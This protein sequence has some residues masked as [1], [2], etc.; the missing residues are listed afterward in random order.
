M[1]IYTKYRYV[2][3][4]NSFVTYGCKYI[5]SA[6]ALI[7][8]SAS[9]RVQNNV[10]NPEEIDFQSQPVQCFWQLPFHLRNI[11][12]PNDKL[13]W[14][15][16]FLISESAIRCFN[17][18]SSSSMHYYLLLEFIMWSMSKL[19]SYT[20]VDRALFASI[21]IIM[22]FWLNKYTLE[23]NFRPDWRQTI[24]INTHNQFMP[25]TRSRLILWADA[26]AIACVGDLFSKTF[27]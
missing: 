19:C 21:I 18:L 16:I 14:I 11:I 26:G 9:S 7:P 3:R 8:V 27:D 5:A 22:I 6:H 24:S 13:N 23:L 15:V 2:L 10:S 4:T 12:I 25:H 1:W 20:N 17:L